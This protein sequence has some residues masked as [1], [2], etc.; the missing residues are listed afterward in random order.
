MQEKLRVRA[1]AWRTLKETYSNVGLIVGIFFVTVTLL[2]WVHDWLGIQLIPPFE[3]TINGIRN[4]LHFLLD[5]ICLRWLALA[6]NWLYYLVTLLLSTFSPILPL[7]PNYRVSGWYVDLVLMSIALLRVFESAYL[8]VP[9]SER[10]AA[11]D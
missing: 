6:F 3:I 1:A 2:N 4:F 8:V 9:R 11:Y 10:D 5:L 7:L